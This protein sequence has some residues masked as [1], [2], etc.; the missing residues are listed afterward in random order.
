L[1]AKLGNPKSN[2][3]EVEINESMREFWAM[4]PGSIYNSPVGA[5]K[6]D[7]SEMVVDP[8]LNILG[9]GVQDEFFEACKGEDIVNGFLNRIAVLE[10]PTLI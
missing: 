1:L 6:D 5:A 3:C 7:N 8:R 2:P 9:F 4:G 10:E